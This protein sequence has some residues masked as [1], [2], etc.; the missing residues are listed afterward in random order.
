M[1][2]MLL[3]LLP[4]EQAVQSCPDCQADITD[5]QMAFLDRA[6][7]EAGF[8]VRTAEFQLIN[9]YRPWQDILA[10]IIHGRSFS[11]PEPA[12]FVP[13]QLEICR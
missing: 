1:S 9:D 4:G 13:P 8:T 6:M 10:A 5:E 3:V 12:A 2:R 7:I 11:L